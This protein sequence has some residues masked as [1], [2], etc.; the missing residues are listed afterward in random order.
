MYLEQIITGLLHIH[1]FL[2][3]C[4]LSL[5]KYFFFL[6]IFTSDNIMQN[7]NSHVSLCLSYAGLLCYNVVYNDHNN[8]KIEFL[9]FCL[10]SDCK[11]NNIVQN[12]NTLVSLSLSC[13][14]LLCYC[15]LH[16]ERKQ[17]TERYW[18]NKL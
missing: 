9:F 11:C 16:I 17:R 1:S 2:S 10:T 18:S 6:I 5:Y 3:F 15:V 12:R 4:C 8:N 14:C 7:R 13:A